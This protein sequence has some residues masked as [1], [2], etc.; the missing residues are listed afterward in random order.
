MLNLS[1][2]QAKLV[3]EAVNYLIDDKWDHLS[4][5]KKERLNLTD[6]DYAR[7]R[8]VDLKLELRR[9]QFIEEINELT[10]IS[11]KMS[12]YL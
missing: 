7:D 8:D 9:R 5:I 2:Q 3:K 4:V 6:E 1:T 10:N 12:D 11:K